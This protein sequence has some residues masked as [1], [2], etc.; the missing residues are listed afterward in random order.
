MRNRRRVSA[1]FKAKAAPEAIEG[2]E[3][4]A[5]L[6]TKHELH[7]T[8]IAAGK[9]EAI[10]KLAKIFDE[11]GSAREQ[12]RDAELTKLHA[13]IGQLVVERDFLSKAFDR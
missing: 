7:P 12:S 5:E 6:A 9:R 2:H 4:V 8:Q 11:K 1:E 13:K 10:E 3:T